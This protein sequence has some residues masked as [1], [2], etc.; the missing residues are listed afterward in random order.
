[1]GHKL[2]GR[3]EVFATA[4]G[5]VPIALAEAFAA[6]PAVGMKLVDRIEV[7]ATAA[8]G[9]PIALAEAFTAGLAVG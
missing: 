4:A 9:V 6:E 2:A 7:F 1:M 3:I 8:G 5:G